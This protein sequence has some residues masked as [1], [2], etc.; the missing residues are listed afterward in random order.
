VKSVR[1]IAI[2]DHLWEL[3]GRMADEMG[4]DREALIN[5]AMHVFARRNGY[6]PSTLALGAATP[7]P[8]PAPTPAPGV[9]AQ[10]PD[11]AVAEQVLAT[12]ARLEREALGA[13]LPPPIPDAAGAERRRALVLVRDDGAETVVSGERF[14]IGRGKH[15]DLVV[16][17]AKV[18]R[19]HAAVVRDG[20]AWAIEDLGS[21]NGTWHRRVRIDRRRIEDGD[22]FFVCAERIRFLLR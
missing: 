4:G 5:Q 6:F 11:G 10:H 2:A 19:E 8:A 20:D 3:F 15:C 1:S 22:E 7:A 9:E 12:A 17:S 18:S 14:V 21:A 16:D 13:P